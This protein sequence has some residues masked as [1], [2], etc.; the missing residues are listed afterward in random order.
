MPFKKDPL[1]Q[2]TT[3]LSELYSTQSRMQVVWTGKKTESDRPSVSTL[4]NVPLQ[5]IKKPPLSLCIYI[6]N[7]FLFSVS[8]VFRPLFSE[9]L[10]NLFYRS[11]V[12]MELEARLEQLENIVSGTRSPLGSLNSGSSPEPPHSWRHLEPTNPNNTHEQIYPSAPPIA[13]NFGNLASNH[14]VA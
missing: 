2:T 8:L 14:Q 3:K 9:H 13:R 4:K 6:T 10:R 12:V 7:D 1:R 5:F 11:N